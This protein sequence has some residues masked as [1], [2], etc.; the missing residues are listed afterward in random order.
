MTIDATQRRLDAEN[1][2]LGSML[3]DADCI[4]GLLAKVNGADFCD[5]ANRVIFQG[6][7]DVFR[8][9]EPVDAVTVCGR[10]GKKYTERL[11]GLMEVTPTSANADVYAGIMHDQAALERV[12]EA[13]DKIAA[14]ETLDAVRPL[15]AS[16]TQAV[17]TSHKLDI[18]TMADV[19]TYFQRS[20]S[21][22]E[23]KKEYI[24]IGIKDVDEGSFLELGDVLVIAG[25]PS[26]GKTAFGLVAAMHM[27]KSHKVGFFS[28]ETRNEKLADR[29]VASGFE[30]DFT[31]IKRRTLDEADWT[32]VAEGGEDFTKRDLRL[33]PCSG[34]S[35]ADVASITAACG[36]DVIFVDYC[37]LI[38]SEVPDR[39][40]SAAQMA[41]VSRSLHTFAQSSGVLVVELLQLSRPERRGGWREP[42]I[43]DLKETGQWEQD[44]DI[45][46][47]LY[48]PDPKSERDQ[49]KCRMLKVAKT[50]RES[51]ASGRLPL[52]VSIR[53]LRWPSTMLTIFARKYRAKR[54]GHPAG[55]RVKIRTHR[56]PGR[57]DFRRSRPRATS[58]FRR[59]I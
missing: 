36:F 6:I 25:E 45:I 17:D 37:Q 13:C 29:L 1:A 8:A 21:D 10:I 48:R 28:L 33:I 46:L 12:Q 4:P 14:A 58:H 32:R 34:V 27:A 54:Q 15:I 43:H 24:S 56:F 2:V 3:I 50:R 55:N 23:A 18:W 51:A 22:E 9:G 57:P 38:R 30:L 49:N 44:A 42:D 7:R 31:R 40:G 39:S 16:M 11:I 53:R 59:T 26:A 19:L 5:T 20:Q 52:T 47:L 35:A 41:E